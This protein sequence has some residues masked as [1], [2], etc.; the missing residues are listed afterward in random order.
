MKAFLV[1]NFV[2]T[3][4]SAEFKR[5]HYHK[6]LYNYFIN[7]TGLKAPPIPPYYSKDFFQ[8]IKQA[9]LEGHEIAHMKVRDWYDLLL[10]ESLTHEKV[11]GE[12]TLKSSRIEILYP[13]IN[14]PNSYQNIRKIGLPTRKM[15][16]LWKLKN[17]LFL[18]EEKKK[19]FNLSPQN[20]CQR[21][22]KVDT[23]GHFLLCTKN[24]NTKMYEEFIDYCKKVDPQLSAIKLLHM[25]ICGEVEV[26]YA[27]GWIL[28]TFVEIQYTKKVY[29]NISE[30]DLIRLALTRDVTTFKSIT[31]KKYDKTVSLIKL[32]LQEFHSN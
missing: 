10:K 16:P 23:A 12:Y 19:Y 29:K 31:S 9:Q 22:Q 21:C 30:E 8:E 28:S 15:S 18:T 20:R 5:N 2:Q 14:H 17:D 11:N 24:E 6:S 13:N 7:G 3:A 26:M 25:D 4:C 1:N 27:I 32:L